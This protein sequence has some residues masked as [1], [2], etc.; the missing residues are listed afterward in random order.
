MTPKKAAMTALYCRVSHQTQKDAIKN[1]EPELKDWAK[2]EGAPA[3]FYRDVCTGAKMNRPQFDRLMQ[4]I[5][6]GKVKR[7]VVWRLDRLGRTAGGLH[8][9]LDELQRLGVTLISVRDGFDLSTSS[10]RLFFGLLASIA[11]YEKEVRQERQALGI[12]RAKAEGK[13]WGGRQP[14]TIVKATPE[15]VATVKKLAK[16]GESIAAIA[17]IVGLSR[18]TLYKLLASG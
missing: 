5:R 11:Q 2:K 10:G 13:R 8:S 4:D 7:I 15:K 1:Q 18:P 12:A 3:K 9:L 17:R 6:R 16:D 14:G